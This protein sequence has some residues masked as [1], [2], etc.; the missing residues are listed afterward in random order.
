MLTQPTSVIDYRKAN[1]ANHLLPK[2]SILSSSGWSDIHLELFQQ[3]EFEIAEHQHT[4]HV[5]AC[6]L[7]N[8]IEESGQNRQVISGER[9]LDGK[10]R[11]ERRGT[12]DIAIIPATMSH[13]CNW[14][15]TVQFM[16][17]A[18]EPILLQ[19]VSQ[20]FLNGDRIE[21][22][23]HF[24][25][26]QDGLIQGIISTL[27]DE[28]EFGKVG[29]NLL[30][31]SLKTTLAIHLLRNYCTTQPKPS[32]YANY[33]NG[34][35]QFTLQQV[36]EYIHEHLHQDLKLIELSAIAQLSPYYFLRLFKQRLGITPHQYI[37][38][39]RIEKAKHL[40]QQTQ[41][42]IADIA[43]QTGF[44][45]QSHMTRCLKQKL[46]MTPKQLLQA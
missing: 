16:V 21:L 40:L 27:R 13:R 41:L 19:Q 28:L 26:Q 25:S 44:S 7:P 14:N 20:D 36:T 22:V 42:S 4:L 18:I 10:L 37:L 32:N 30:I 29:G 9:W 8:L 15:T 43:L 38:Q 23:P 12:G 5:M 6:G 1:A 3:P 34:L 11:Q 24:M 31:D 45:D 17:L 46:G 35:S 2:P 39:C 33:A